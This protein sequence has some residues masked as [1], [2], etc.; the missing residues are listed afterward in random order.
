MTEK[1]LKI[2][3]SL[4]SIRSPQMIEAFELVYVNGWPLP[5]AIKMAKVT[6]SNF[7]KARKKFEEVEE[8][9]NQLIILDRESK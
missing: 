4:T 8:K 3:L 1:K 6:N 5:H 2:L 9:V 7:C